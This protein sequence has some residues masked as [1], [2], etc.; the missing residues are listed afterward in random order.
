MVITHTH[1]SS[2][3]AYAE[4]EE[5]KQ[6]QRESLQPASQRLR[7]ASQQQF[8]LDNKRRMGYKDSS[9][10][11]DPHI[12]SSYPLH[13]SRSNH[14]SNVNQS[15][16]QAQ[17]KSTHQP[18]MCRTTTKT[19]DDP[20]PYDPSTTGTNPVDSPAVNVPYNYKDHGRPSPTRPE[21]PIRNA[22]RW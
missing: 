18:S 4:R 5:Q 8:Y 1:I 12:H 14:D 9:Q 11:S 15:K 20:P 3:R 6:K 22:G 19:M 16:P 10:K 21:P 17:S 13:G 2:T 7:H